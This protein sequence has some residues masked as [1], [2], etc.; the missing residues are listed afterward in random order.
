MQLLLKVE[1]FQNFGIEYYQNFTLKC[2]K[3]LTSYF[4]TYLR[5]VCIKCNKRLF[6]MEFRKFNL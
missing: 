2:K 3:K 5:K 4:F 6:E 1:T